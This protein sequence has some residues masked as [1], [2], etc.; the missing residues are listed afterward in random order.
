MKQLFWMPHALKIG[1]ALI[2]MQFRPVIKKEKCREVA[3][4][5]FTR[6]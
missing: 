2:S 6:Q 3:I 1:G 5:F 4:Q